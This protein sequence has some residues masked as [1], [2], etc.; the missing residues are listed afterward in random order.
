MVNRK[1]EIDKTGQSSSFSLQCNNLKVE[2]LNPSE[3]R[4]DP[5]LFP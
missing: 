1:L 5:Q 2:T 4:L 3:P